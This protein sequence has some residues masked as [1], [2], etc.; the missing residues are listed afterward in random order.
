ML[1]R[2]WI[3]ARALALYPTFGF[4]SAAQ[5]RAQF[6][7]ILSMIKHFQQFLHSLEAR[8]QL[9]K[10]ERQKSVLSNREGLSVCQL[11][12]VIA[13]HVLKQKGA[14]ASNEINKRC[15]PLFHLLSV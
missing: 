11:S 3:R 2:F 14:R 7:H 6:S 13:V 10:Q 5:T 8:Q 4:F 9:E 12:L 15:N 1:P